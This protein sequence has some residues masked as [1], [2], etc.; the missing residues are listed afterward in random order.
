M[1]DKP[2]FTPG[3]WHVEIV[4]YGCY[5]CNEYGLHVS[6]FDGSHFDTDSD[7]AN[8]YLIAA[9][10][11]MYASLQ[12]CVNLLR[13]LGLNRFACMVETTLRQARGENEVSK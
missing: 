8:A 3:T 7:I 5:V 6:T 11:A 10:P 13:H 4:R 12:N 2:K 9:A 1:T